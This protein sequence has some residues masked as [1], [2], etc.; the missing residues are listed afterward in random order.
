MVTVCAELVAAGA[1]KVA[2][3]PLPAMVPALAVQ[4]TPSLFLSFVTVAVRVT[5]FAASTVAVAGVTARVTGLELPPQPAM[6]TTVKSV[7]ANQHEAAL[8]LRPDE[9]SLL[10]NMK[11]S[12]K[13]SRTVSRG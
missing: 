7:K 10:Q 4:V 2:E 6:L 1:V 5:V 13:D 3:L 8:T 9:T 11:A 12:K